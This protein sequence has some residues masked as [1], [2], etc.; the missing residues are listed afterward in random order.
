MSGIEPLT[1]RSAVECSTTE[2]HSHYVFRILCLTG[3]MFFSG[4]FKENKTLAKRLLELRSVSSISFGVCEAEMAAH[5]A[6]R[7]ERV[8]LFS[9]DR[10]CIGKKRTAALF[11]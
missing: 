5:T 4:E 2:L 8:R 1:S 9:S 7:Q 10:E 3:I 11:D 6:K